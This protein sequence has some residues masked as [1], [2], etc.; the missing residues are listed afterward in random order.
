[1]KVSV[2][3]LSEW[4]TSSLPTAALGERLTM[5]GLEVDSIEPVAP[6]LTGITV[7][8]IVESSAHPQADRLTVCRVEIGGDAIAEVVCGAPNARSGLL[9]AYAAPGTALPDGRVIEHAVIRNVASAGM[10]CSAAELALGDD[11]DG[12][13]ELADDAPVGTPIDE[14]LQLADE[15]IDIELTPNRGDCLSVV[16]VAREVAVLTDVPMRDVV[17][18]E[19]SAAIDDAFPVAIEAPG[20]CPRYAGRIIRHVDAAAPTP[21][22]IKERL[23]RAGVRSI[24]AVVDVTNYVMLELGQPLHGFDLERLV[25]GIRVRNGRDGESLALLDGQT[26]ELDSETLVIADEERAVALA[27]VM[28]GAATGVEAHSTNIFLESAY[29][30]AITLAGVARRY[31]M[32]T[33]ASHRFER[34]V[35]FTGQE[36][37]IER[38]TAMIM[39]I[40]GG[41][42][43]PLVV[44]EFPA[45]IPTRA[46]IPFDPAEIERIIGIKMDAGQAE[47][48]FTALHC[49]VVERDSRLEVTPPAFRFDLESG[50][51]LLEEVARVHGYDNI[52]AT[53]PSAEMTLVSG[54]PRHESDRRIR[55]KLI[56]QGYFEA[57]TY[58]FIDARSGYLVAPTR[59][60][61]ELSNPITS[62]MAVMRT[63]MWPGLITAALHNLNR[64]IQ[65]LR[66]FE[67]GA[68]FELDYD[69]LQQRH[70]L[71]GLALGQ[72]RPE[73]WGETSREVDYYDIKQEV[74]SVL[75]T[76]GLAPGEWSAVSDPALHP[77]QAAAIETGGR[78]IGKVGVLHPRIA[79]QFGLEQLAIVFELEL[80]K[81]PPTGAPAYTPISKFPSVRRDIS[82]VLDRTVAAAAVLDTIRSAAG[83]LLRDLQLFDEY[84]GQGIDSDKK[85]L[86]MG[87]I[88]QASSSTLRDEEIEETMERVLL[89]LHAD[90]GGTLRK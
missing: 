86:A 61:H 64:Q 80:E 62:D 43:G 3:W 24:S 70:M 23:R 29:F 57:I 87:L 28:G 40:C 53:L 13:M 8:R 45:A 4:V 77:G 59:R 14:Y 47:K 25:G 71:A 58:S 44:A 46:P 52:P 79:Q 17:I 12:L 63:S 88:F 1:M 68:V 6:A 37:S 19:V 54:A 21:V 85:S 84:R 41:A 56:T 20:G 2:Q 31:R 76:L 27:G 72:A 11:A 66:L 69:G 5:A 67:L 89:Q 81:L 35:D 42:P 78:T 38:A 7:A 60:P 9:V 22:W 49:R 75:V 50:A 34:G 74:E 36:R 16:G 83:D 10:L 26:I 55:E 30:D 90:F 32:H 15:V 73:Q 39:E 48:V 51:D 82:V 65:D 18:P 33:D